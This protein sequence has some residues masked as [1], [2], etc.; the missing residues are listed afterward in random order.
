MLRLHPALAVALGAD[1]RPAERGEP[2]VSNVRGIGDAASCG[3]MS[4]IS[5]RDGP[6]VG[7]CLPGKVRPMSR[8]RGVANL[9]AQAALV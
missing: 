9:V 1:Q 8:A 7:H 3:T 2:R 5:T 6:A 4:A